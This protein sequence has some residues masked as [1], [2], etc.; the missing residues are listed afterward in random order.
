[1]IEK[2]NSLEEMVTL[3]E[4]MRDEVALKVHLGKAEAAE[5]LKKLEKKWLTFQK[6]YKPLADEAGK[7]VENTAS[8]LSLAAEELKSGYIRLKKLL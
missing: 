8:A 3:V 2:P 7:T 1:M 4:K 5:E 6:Q